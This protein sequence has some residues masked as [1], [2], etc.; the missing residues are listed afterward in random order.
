MAREKHVITSPINGKPIHRGTVVRVNFTFSSDTPGQAPIG[1]VER[2]LLNDPTYGSRPF[3]SVLI[4][5]YTGGTKEQ[6]QTNRMVEADTHP[7]SRRYQ[8]GVQRWGAQW[9]QEAVCRAIPIS[10]SRLEPIGQVKRMPKCVKGRWVLPSSRILAHRVSDVTK[11]IK[12]LSDGTPASKMVRLDYKLENM[13]TGPRRHR[14][15]K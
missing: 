2:L 9:R 4:A 14:Y 13:T 10:I 8:Y 1:V 12:N 11:Q 15:K 3:A 6:Q 5:P 7:G